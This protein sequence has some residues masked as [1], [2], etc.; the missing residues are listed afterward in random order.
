M[1]V[2]QGKKL[3]VKITGASHAEK[4]TTEIS[5]LSDVSDIDKNELQRYVNLRSPGRYLTTERKEADKL[6]FVKMTDG[7]FVCDVKNENSKSSDYSSVNLVPRPSHADYAAIKKFGENVDLKGGGKF[8]GRMTIGLSI[9]GGI[10]K[11]RLEGRGIKIVS[12]LSKVGNAVGRCYKTDDIKKSDIILSEKLPAFSCD[13]ELFEKEIFS[14]KERKDS[15]GGRV[16]CIIF[17]LKESLGD[18]LFDGFECGL[19]SL[20]FAIPAVKGVEFGDGFDFCGEY[21]KNANDEY[22][23][24]DGKIIT[25]SNRNGGI[26][27]GMTFGNDIRF[28]VAIKPTPS[29]GLPQKSV[30]L[31]ELTEK[32]LEICGRH[33]PCVAVRAAY[34]VEAAA[35]LYVYDLLEENNA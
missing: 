2:W 28:A 33:D 5:G 35:N 19:S 1:S 10:A 21:G 29:I 11:Q 22:A 3:K 20:L 17:G 27:G 32:T 8:S 25:L 13:E 18:S 30:D 24:K 26:L 12:Y 23:V 6:C 16:E 7:A 4:I 31:K 14:A 34:V 9:A 15:V